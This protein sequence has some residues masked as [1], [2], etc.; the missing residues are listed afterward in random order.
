MAVFNGGNTAAGGVYGLLEVCVHIYLFLE[1]RGDLNKICFNKTAFAA[2]L[3]GSPVWAPILV[4]CFGLQVSEYVTW[5]IT[6]NTI[7]LHIV[8]LCEVC[9]VTFEWFLFNSMVIL[10]AVDCGRCFFYLDHLLYACLPQR[11][12]FLK[13][14]KQNTFPELLM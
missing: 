7:Y 1:L 11:S 2:S 10:M 13:V 5:L 3:R 9:K 12:Q 4:C 6:M 8:L 14:Q